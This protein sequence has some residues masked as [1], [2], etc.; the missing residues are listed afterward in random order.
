M[1]QPVQL[2]L[3]QCAAML[4]IEEVRPIKGLQGAPARLRSP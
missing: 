4:P 1:Q 2:T 3:E